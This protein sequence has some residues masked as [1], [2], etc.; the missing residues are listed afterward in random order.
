MNTT[1]KLTAAIALSTMA[2]A[3]MRPG[4]CPERAQNKPSETFDTY[5]MAGL[6]YEYVWE[7][8]FQ[9]H[10]NYKC[11]TWIMLSDEEENGPG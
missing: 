7:G 2:K 10:H 5:S 8:E 11:S 3:E 1:L 6:W 4:S 9:K